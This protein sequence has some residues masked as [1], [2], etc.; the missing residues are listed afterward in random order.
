MEVYSVDSVTSVDPE[1]NRSTEYQPFYSY[2]HAQHQDNLQTFW[3]APRKQST[4]END[5]G[6]DVFLHMVDLGF[7]PRL[8]A[9]S[10]LVVRTTCSNRN[11]PAVLQRAGEQLA[12]ELEGAAPLARIRCPRP[13]T[14]PLAPPLGRGAHWRL[15]SHL[16]LNHLSLT[17]P[18]EA[19]AALQEILR[20]YD[21]SGADGNSQMASVTRLLIDGIQS[22]S[23]R[24]VVERTSGGASS[25]FAHGVE[26]TIEFDEQKYVGTGVFLFASVLERFLALYASL[27]SFTQLIARTT[28]AERYF[29]KWPPRAGELPML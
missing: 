8:P 14:L 15:I 29:K 18:R 12:L 2:R 23:S 20:L 22:V 24:R 16:S 17:D 25:G 1:T 27:N 6:T 13:P 10:T 21:F 3:Y 11:L 9:E 26:V 28:Q 7:N 19:R 4:Q 5:R